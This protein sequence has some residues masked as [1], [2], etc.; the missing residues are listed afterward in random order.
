MKFDAK[1]RPGDTIEPKVKWLNSRRM[2]TDTWSPKKVK[3][4]ERYIE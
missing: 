4:L 1:Y 2:P 3:I